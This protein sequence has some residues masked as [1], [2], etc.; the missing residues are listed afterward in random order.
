MQDMK[1]GRYYCGEDITS[2]TLLRLC[3]KAVLCWEE[4]GKCLVFKG[5]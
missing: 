4:L 3:H 5:I 2:F 1:I